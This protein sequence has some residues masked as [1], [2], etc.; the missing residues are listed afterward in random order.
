MASKRDYYEILGVSKGA[1]A[2]EIKSA[3]RKLARKHHPD[4][5]KSSGADIRFKE[6]GEAYQVLS[7]PQKKGAYDQ[8]GHSAFAPGGGFGGQGS[9]FRGA[10]G[11]QQYSWST[12]GGNPNLGPERAR[13]WST[14]F[15]LHPRA[16]AGLNLSVTYFDIDYTDRVAQ[17][18]N[19]GALGALTNPA[20]QEFIDY[21][22]SAAQQAAVIDRAARGLRNST[23][24]PY[25]PS[26]VVAIINNI[27]VNAAH[28]RIH[29]VD[30][31][32]TY[33][34][35]LTTGDI[36]LSG[37]ASWLSSRQR[38]TQTLPAFELAGTNYNPPHFRSRAGVTGHLGRITAALFANYIGPIVDENASPPAKGG[39]MTT[40]DVSLMWKTPDST[41][42]FKGLELGLFVQNIANAKPPYLAPFSDNTINYDSTNYSP[43]G[44]FVSLSLRKAW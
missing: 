8:F 21:A 44:R 35:P 22:P 10:G 33:R 34:I 27:P 20:V 6:I 18:V 9:P 26:K 11:W 42:P 14:T 1:S 19:N 13:T 37:Q 12:G 36:V 29:G 4:I 31:G 32:G 23:G 30:L 25:D 3:Y 43:L 41:G 24:A 7:D 40:L 16:L 2:D 15:D 28:Q 5:D 39:D 38:N 17:P